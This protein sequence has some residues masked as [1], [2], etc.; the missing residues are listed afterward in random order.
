MLGGFARSPDRTWH[1]ETSAASAR[2]AV[3][4]RLSGEPTPMVGR[5]RV[6]WYRRDQKKEVPDERRRSYRS[7]PQCAAIFPSGAFAA[8]LDRLIEDL[9]PATPPAQ[10]EAH[11]ARRR[12]GQW[13]AVRRLALG[14]TAD[15]IADRAGVD[16]ETLA[17]VELGVAEEREAGALAWDRLY[18]LLGARLNDEDWVAAVAE[19]ALGRRPP[20]NEIM[21]RVAEQLRPACE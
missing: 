16:A 8:A 1:A 5:K 21:G 11:R 4:V 14:L 2:A 7:Q 10:R 13:L 19:V 18:V 3:P 6:A 17:R 20:S 15:Q 9:A 12:C